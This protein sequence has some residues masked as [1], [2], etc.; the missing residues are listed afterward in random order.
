M[1]AAGANKV[2]LSTSWTGGTSKNQGNASY[3]PDGTWVV[4]QMQSDSSSLGC[5]GSLATTGIGID[6]DT[7]VCKVSTNVCSKITAN[8]IDGT[9]GIMRPR[10][11][12]DGKKIWYLS[13]TGLASRL[14]LGFL[15]ICDFNAAVPNLIN[16]QNVIPLHGNLWY[17]PTD[18]DPTENPTCT[19]YFQSV[20]LGQ[21]LDDF[22]VWKWNSCTLTEPVP[23]TPGNLYSEF[24]RQSPTGDLAI[25]TTSAFAPSPQIHHFPDTFD[26]ALADA[27][28]GQNEI[29]LT[30]FNNPGSS[31]Y[32]PSNGLVTVSEGSFD[33]TG[34]HIIVGIQKAGPGTLHVYKWDIVNTGVHP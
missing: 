24:W 32:I 28:S 2:D 8:P 4:L 22:K 14:P 19:L 5:I 6:H 13:I 26:L 12:R 9:H 1:N 33:S 3:S 31:D 15:Q 30:C 11:T 21:T 23:L 18:S 16:C 10:W 34:A 25:F 7:Y 17:E 27:H 20:G 29:P